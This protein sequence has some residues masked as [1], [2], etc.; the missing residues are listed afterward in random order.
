MAKPYLES[1]CRWPNLTRKTLKSSLTLYQQ[2]WSFS[3]KISQR[4]SLLR[5]RFN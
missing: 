1:V 4:K 2:F 5:C 3:Q